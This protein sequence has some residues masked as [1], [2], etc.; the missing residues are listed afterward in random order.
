MYFLDTYMKIGNAFRELKAR[1]ILTSRG[2]PTVEVELHTIFGIFFASCPS[3]ASTGAN[4]AVVLLDND[5]SKFLGKG[6]EKAIANIRNIIVPSLE[7]IYEIRISEQS[8]I[9]QFLVYL[10][11]SDNKRRIGANAILPVS[12][13]FCR[14]GAASLGLKLHEFVSQISGSK[15]RIPLPCFN[16]LNGGIHS[17]NGLLFQEIMIFFDYDS[18]D[19]NLEQGVI[20][21]E[22]LK[23]VIIAKHGK[24]SIGL[25]DEGGFAPPIDTL[26]QALDLIMEAYDKG[27]FTNFHIALDCAANEIYKDDKYEVKY[28]CGKVSS[29][30]SGGQLADYYLTILDKYKLICSIEDPFEENDHLSW[31][32][33]ME[34]VKDRKI[35]IVADDL[36][37]TN[38]KYIQMAI[39]SKLCNVLL[40]KLNQ[41]GTVSETIESV[42]LARDNKMKIKVSHRSGE[43]EDAFISDFSV[44]LGADYIKT[45]APCR[46]ERVIK[47]NQL[48]RIYE[49]ITK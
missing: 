6:V 44:G 38:S 17:G 32:S 22:T 28:E 18:Y 33:F 24:I 35:N 9:D 15:I 1:M 31:A 11:A 16:V 21:Y 30:I 41:I 8:K 7:K 23:K 27:D 45:G 42:I 40:V 43:T 19:K 48:L 47:Y 34:K 14:A 12:L 37:V 13:A 36:T 26:E 2:E 4:E 3:G 10:D 20:F 49:D 25:G 46:G 29:L 39:N 5:Q